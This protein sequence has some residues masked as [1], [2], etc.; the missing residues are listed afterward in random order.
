VADLEEEEAKV[1]AA[2]VVEDIMD[3]EVE[4]VVVT[5]EGVDAVTL[6]II[7]NKMN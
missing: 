3:V 4:V 1:V 2:T 7:T 5:P 6:A